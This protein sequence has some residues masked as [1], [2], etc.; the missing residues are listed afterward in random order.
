MADRVLSL[1]TI[2]TPHRGSP[3]ADQLP[4]GTGQLLAQ[5]GIDIQGAA[6]LTTQA[7]ARF[8]EEVLDSPKVR[9]FSVAGEYNPGLFDLLR[10]LQEFI[11]NKDR[12]NDGLVSVNSAKFGQLEENWTFL[13]R[14]PA[15]HFRLINWGTHIFLT[16]LE[17]ADETIVDQ[18]KI[19]AKRLGELEEL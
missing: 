16:P 7:C 10:P 17:Q 18:Y 5:L 19:L 1:T 13:G 6:D 4:I 12:E 11:M 9:Y 2:G 3:I 8:N 15:S 14:W